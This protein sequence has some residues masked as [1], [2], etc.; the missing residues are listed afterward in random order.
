MADSPLPPVHEFEL[1]SKQGSTRF[2]L[3]TSQQPEDV[4]EI[5]STLWPNYTIT[6][7]GVHE[8]PAESTN[9]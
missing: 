8:D 7:L 6:Y 9:V 1:A 2:L 5:Y 3:Y 4:H